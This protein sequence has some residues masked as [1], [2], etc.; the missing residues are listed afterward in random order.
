VGEREDD[1]IACG[2]GKNER[3]KRIDRYLPLLRDVWSGKP[4]ADGIGPVGP[5]PVSEGG[6]ELLFGGFS[7]AAVQRVAKWGSGYISPGR[8]EHSGWMFGR[9]MGAWNDAGREGKPKLIAQANTALGSPWV[10]DEAQK[11]VR[12]YYSFLDAPGSGATFT[13]ED[14]VNLMLTSEGQIREAIAACERTG[15]HEMVFVFWAADPGQIGRLASAV[16]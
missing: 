4:Y 14:V 9:I 7:E 3:A 2:V 6:P 5:K 1:F 16:E 13:S 12:S 8:A 11:L 15:V 10:I